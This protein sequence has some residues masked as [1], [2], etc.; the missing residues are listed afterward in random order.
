VNKQPS[1]IALGALAVLGL[2]AASCGDDDD[3]GTTGTEA[4]AGTEA[5]A[6]TEAPAGGE[7]A[8][9]EVELATADS[10]FGTI[11][12]DQEGL[13]LYMFIP[14]AQGEPTCEGDC[15][16][17]WPAFLGTATAG[18]GVDES[19]ITSVPRADGGGDQVSY[20]DWPLY[21]F[22]EDSAAGDVNGQGV[23][24]VWYLMS[25]DGEPIEESAT[26]TS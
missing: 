17:A 18:E 26:P 7:A 6:G 3:G 13:S 15:A 2:V 25:P 21:Y 5:A 23:G 14:D 12:V 4:P 22:A 9:G 20:N 1:R 16:A 24:D 11:L 10:E 8:G 19:L